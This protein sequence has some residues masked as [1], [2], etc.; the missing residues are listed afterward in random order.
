RI[1][2]APGLRW[3]VWGLDTDGAGVSAYLF[4]TPEAAEAFAAGPVIAGLKANPAVQGVSLA[5]APVD[6]ALS[7]L[8]HA[9]FAA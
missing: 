4:D 3:K 2:G 5:R 6:A 1:A 8:T 9:A 7:Q